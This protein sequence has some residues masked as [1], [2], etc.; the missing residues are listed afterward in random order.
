MIQAIL[1]DVDG[2]LNKSEKLKAQ[3]YAIAVQ[4]LRG[5]SEPYLRQRPSR[6]LPYG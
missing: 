1:F 3:S 5:L 2:T 4:C 6:P